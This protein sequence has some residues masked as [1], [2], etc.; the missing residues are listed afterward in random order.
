MGVVLR[1]A[2]ACESAGGVAGAHGGRPRAGPVFS[3]V[4]VS[5]KVLWAG[6]ET[7]AIR[8]GLAPSGQGRFSH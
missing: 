8:S 6:V 1:A 4:Q 7:T 5:P 3:R 2:E